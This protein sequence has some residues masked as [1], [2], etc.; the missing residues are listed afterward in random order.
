MVLGGPVYLGTVYPFGIFVSQSNF[1]SL[2]YPQA[3]CDDCNNNNNN[4]D[5]DDG[6]DDNDPRK[7]VGGH[8]SQRFFFFF[9]YF[10]I[11]IIII[12]KRLRNIVVI[13]YLLGDW[14]VC[15]CVFIIFLIDRWFAP[16]I[17]QKKTP[18]ASSDIFSLGLVR[19]ELVTHERP[20]CE[21]G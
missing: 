14:F 1:Y 9:F 19:W 5:D 18:T 12:I 4:S 15:L 11:I 6:D 21:L 7:L 13:L 2:A 17:V 20:F 3:K 8:E 16:E 10:I